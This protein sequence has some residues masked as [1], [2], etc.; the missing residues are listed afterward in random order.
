MIASNK[1]LPKFEYR[2]LAFTISA[3]S[4]PHLRFT[5]GIIL[6]L[7]ATSYSNYTQVS[8][9]AF[10]ISISMFGNMQDGRLSP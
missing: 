5:R 10:V 4:T 6:A 9:A 3:I 1:P 2:I 7:D 8:M